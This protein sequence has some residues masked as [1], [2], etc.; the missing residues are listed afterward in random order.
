MAFKKQKLA[1]PFIYFL[2][3]TLT[4]DQHMLFFSEYFNGFLLAWYST[5]INNIDS[6]FKMKKEE[7]KFQ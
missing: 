4:F 2:L 6:Y 1:W 5:L 3:D 7:R